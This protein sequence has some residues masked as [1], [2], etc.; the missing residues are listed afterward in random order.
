MPQ[1]M[2]GFALRFKV[3][4]DKNKSSLGKTNMLISVKEQN[5]D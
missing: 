5:A 1:H 2:Y 3:Y 4:L